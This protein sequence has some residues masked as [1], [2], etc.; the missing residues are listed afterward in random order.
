MFDCCCVYISYPCVFSE[1]TFERIETMRAFAGAFVCTA[2]CE[3]YI[4]RIVY[5]VKGRL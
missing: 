2:V 4:N 5:V 1:V 3:D